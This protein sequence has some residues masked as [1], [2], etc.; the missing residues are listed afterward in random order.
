M[1]GPKIQQSTGTPSPERALGRPKLCPRKPGDARGH[2]R[3]SEGSRRQATGR[4][5][6]A[7]SR[8]GDAPSPPPRGSPSGPSHCP[9]QGKEIKSA[10]EAPRRA[11]R[12]SR[13]PGDVSELGA[14]RN[15]NRNTKQRRRCGRFLLPWSGPPGAR[16]REYTSCASRSSSRREPSLPATSPPRSPAPTR[17]ARAEPTFFIGASGAG[18]ELGRPEDTARQWTSESTRWAVP[19]D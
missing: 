4:S 11:D 14:G 17:R 12:T 1:A 5:R 19:S 18:L 10:R 15:W 9:P 8:G 7:L 13:A 2:T 16:P 3:P 6:R